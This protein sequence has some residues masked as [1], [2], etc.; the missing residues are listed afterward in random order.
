MNKVSKSIKKYRTASGLS[1]NELANKLFVT[2]Q[3]VSSW[4]N[5][6]T[7]PDIEALQKL[8]EALSVSVE[9]LIYGELPKLVDDGKNEKAQKTMTVIFS[10]LASL[11][12]GV[13]GILVFV[14]YWNEFPVALQTA[15]SVL[16]MLIGQAVAIWVFKKKYEKTEWRES[17][18][19]IWCAGVIA[20]TVLCNTVLEYLVDIDILLI[21][22]AVL[23]LP[24][25]YILNAVSPL[26]IYYSLV[27]IFSFADLK[28]LTLVLLILLG[29]FYVFLHRNDSDDLRHIY[30]VWLTVIAF[31][32]VAVTAGYISEELFFTPFI[33]I[34]I[35]LYSLKDRWNLALPCGILMPIALAASSV[36]LTVMLEPSDYGYDDR[37][38]FGVPKIAMI[39]MSVAITVYSA[40]SIIKSYREDKAEFAYAVSLCAT[41]LLT[42][43]MI[44]GKLAG[45][46]IIYAFSYAA[47]MLQGFSLFISGAKKNKFLPV[48]IG[49]VTIIS[50]IMEIVFMQ[51]I[52]ILFVGIILITFGVALFFINY[53]LVKKSKKKTSG[54]NTNE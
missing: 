10:V 27:I 50:L 28:F 41:F 5:G 2:R 51:E 13:G 19:V 35:W 45:N 52:D 20:T 33:A 15:F 7:Q 44:S 32:A 4:E 46:P 23:I 48:N 16:P 22:N 36:I 37:I 12:V 38:S 54:G 31:I 24:V 18:A 9:E 1:Q 11:L 47:V 42:L 17:S 3:T 40:F 53:R 43:A 21:A 49:L 29:A 39:I 8:S 6:R 25:I 30:S 34:M 26:I 14:N